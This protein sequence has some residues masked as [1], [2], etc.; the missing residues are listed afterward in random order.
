MS[1]ARRNLARW[2]LAVEALTPASIASSVAVSAWPPINALNILARAGSPMAAA[3]AARSGSPS[4]RAARR[5]LLTAAPHPGSGDGAP[6][7]D[8]IHDEDQLMVMVAVHHLDIDT[9]V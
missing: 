5:R 2:L 9:G 6:A 1:P 8:V 7:R 4:T 3:I